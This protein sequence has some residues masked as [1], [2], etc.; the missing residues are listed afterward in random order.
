MFITVFILNLSRCIVILVGM[1]L[2]GD[3]KIQTTCIA[4]IAR[5]AEAATLRLQQLI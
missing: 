1:I 3:E 4:S 2:L 5:T